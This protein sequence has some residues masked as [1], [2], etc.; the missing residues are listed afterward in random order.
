MIGIYRVYLKTTLALQFQYRAAMAIWMFN[1]IVEPTV[2]LVVWRT[3]AAARGGVGGYDAADFAAYFI[4]LMVAN[5]LTFSWIIHEFEW[6]VRSGELSSMLLKPI[7]PIHSDVADNLGYKA[8]TLVILAPAAVLL[9]LLFEPAFTFEAG[10]LAL[11]APALAAAYGI[12]IL[13]DWTFAMAAFWTTRTAALNRIYFLVLLFCSG[14]LA[15]LSLLQCWM[16][17]ITWY[18]PFRWV[19]WFPVELALGRLSP[20]LIAAGFRM[21]ALWLAAGLALLGVVWRL[22][23][24][25][26]AAVGS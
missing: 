2:Y 22:G 5:Q 10:M 12:R 1:R 11:A 13:F 26:Y 25:K 18:V 21:Q 6:R 24:R 4:V 14:R 9:S 23:I 20:E 3:V 16:A 7:H 19:V 17:R 15:P 8:L